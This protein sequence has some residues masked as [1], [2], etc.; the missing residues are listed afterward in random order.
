VL[1]QVEIE[2]DKLR[3]M[4]NDRQREYLCYFILL[5]WLTSFT[6]IVLKLEGAGAGDD[7]LDKG[8]IVVRFWTEG[9]ADAGAVAV[10]DARTAVKVNLEGD[11]AAKSL[12]TVVSKLRLFVSVV[13][14]A[15]QVC[16]K[17]S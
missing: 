12:E 8:E 9:L 1:G 6:E 14:E 7:I 10:V 16:V 17:S 11:S 4:G 15:A 5:I 3:N 2:I 13:D